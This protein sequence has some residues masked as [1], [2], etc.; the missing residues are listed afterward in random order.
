MPL[1]IADGFGPHLDVVDR[2]NGILLTTPK[3]R[4][5]LGCASVID[6]NRQYCTR[7][8]GSSDS[9]AGTGTGSGSGSENT[10]GEV[11]N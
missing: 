7:T 8:S 9:E 5:D 10:S 4:K 2:A 3:V 6:R 11:A 1:V